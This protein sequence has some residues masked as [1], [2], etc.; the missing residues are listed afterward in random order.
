VRF[1]SLLAL[2]FGLF[3]ISPSSAAVAYLT[4]RP[5]S[6]QALIAAGDYVPLS[7]DYVAE[8]NFSPAVGSNLLGPPTV[9]SGDYLALSPN[10][11]IDGV[12]YWSTFGHDME[13][14]WGSSIPGFGPYGSSTYRTRFS[15]FALGTESV[16]IDG[17]WRDEISFVNLDSLLSPGAL[18]SI[19]DTTY[20]PSGSERSATYW[21]RLTGISTNNPLQQIPEPATALLLLA[22]LAAIGRL[23]TPIF[24]AARS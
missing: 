7:K 20:W 17:F 10:T 9:Q 14:V 4:F 23:G 19:Y 15:I 1:F 3:P 24:G 13:L 21:A 22:G 12:G 11:P 18:W 6:V 2:L 16:S 8:V 5:E